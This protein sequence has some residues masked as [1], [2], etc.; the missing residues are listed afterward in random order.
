MLILTGRLGYSCSECLSPIFLLP[1]TSSLSFFLLVII[2]GHIF[3]PLRWLLIMSSN[4]QREQARDSPRQR[5]EPLPG[6]SASDGEPAATRSRSGEAGDSSEPV[7]RTRSANLPGQGSHG[8]SQAR[9]RPSRSPPHASS[10]DASSRPVRTESAGS[11]S[12]NTRRGTPDSSST[13]PR[14]RGA[15][16]DPNLN[17]AAAAAAVAA[18]A[19]SIASQLHASPPGGRVHTGQRAFE[20]GGSQGAAARELSTRE[21]NTHLARSLGEFW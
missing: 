17:A 19:A 1:S 7:Q 8:D 13:Q 18:G 10:R 5:A 15:A 11:A 14:P 9:S 16:R 20:L 4:R 21:I 3:Q 2:S 6:S 12:Q